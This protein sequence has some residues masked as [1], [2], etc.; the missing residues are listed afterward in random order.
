[1][2]SGA[3]LELQWWRRVAGTDDRFLHR[4][5]WVPW[6]WLAPCQAILFVG[7]SRCFS[8]RCFWLIYFPCFILAMHINTCLAHASG[9]SISQLIK[10]LLWS[11]DFPPPV[12]LELPPTGLLTCTLLVFCY[13]YH[14][15]MKTDINSF[16]SNAGS[17]VN[18]SNLHLWL[19]LPDSANRNTRCLVKVVLPINIRSMFRRSTSQENIIQI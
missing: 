10:G 19:A 1:M 18:M 13:L 16:S 14:A 15:G 12:F 6:C 4:K 7:D 9:S 5:S 17:F 3:A 8:Y 2:L 11:R